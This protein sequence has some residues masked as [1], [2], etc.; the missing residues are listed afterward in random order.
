MSNQ[1]SD[2]VWNQVW[3]NPDGWYPNEFI[4]RF[5][6]K[7]VRK[8]IGLDTYQVRRGDIKR[9]LDLGCGCGRHLV[10]LTREGYDTYGLDISQRAIAFAQ[11]WL[12][13][14]GLKADLRVGS[15][16]NLPWGEGS[17]DLV[18][19]H[20][21]LDH[22]RWEDARR[23]TKEVARV[24]KP[25]GLFYVSLVSTRESGYGQGQQ[26]DQYTYLV[27]EGIEARTVQRFYE[28]EH[29]FELLNDSFEVLDVVHDEW[30][31]VYGVGFSALDRDGYPRLARFH[32][33]AQKP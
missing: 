30:Q 16:I 7:Y 13:R 28:F 12:E 19:S 8:R 23:A 11:Q 6:A 15:A 5:L 1:V 22:M 14:E 24:L 2:S 20:G 32:V 26:M 33:A 9:V 10:M 31:A 18:I 21:V 27:Q 3:K 29:I 4:V 17:F 25:Q